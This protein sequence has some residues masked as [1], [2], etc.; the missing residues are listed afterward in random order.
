MANVTSEHRFVNMSVDQLKQ[1][2]ALLSLAGF[3]GAMIDFRT[4]STGFC[5]AVTMK[6]F[7]PIDEPKVG[8]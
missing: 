2:L 6:M 5:S 7:K 4:A 8:K 1:E 3:G